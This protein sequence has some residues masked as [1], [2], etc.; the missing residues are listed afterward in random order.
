MGTAWLIFKSLLLLGGL[1]AAVA[2]VLARWWR[3]SD[4]RPKLAVRWGLT[5][6]DLAFIAFVVGPLL[7]S[8]GFTAAFGGVPMAAVAGLILA[9]V[10]T[11]SLTES[12]GRKLVAI[13]DGGDLPPDPKPVYSVAESRR[14]AGRTA[15]ALAELRTQ[16]EQ[17][18][19]DFRLWMMLAEIHADDLHDLETATQAVDQVV[20]QP[21]HAP[22]NVA[23]ALTRLADW[24][25]KYARDPAA[26]REAFERIIQQFPDSEEAHFAHQR[27]AHL[28]TAETLGQ[29]SDRTPL[30]VPHSDE[31]FG[32]RPDFKGLQ[33]PTT[34]PEEEAAR[35]VRQ[36]ERYPHDNQ[37]RE[38]LAQ[39]YVQQ[40]RR[41]DLA[42]EQMEQLIAQPHAPPRQVVHWLNQLA[43]WQL[44]EADNLALARATLERIIARFPDNAVAETA[45]R[46]LATLP[47]EARAN[48]ESQVVQLG[49]YEQ[50]LGLKAKTPPPKGD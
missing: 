46:R 33:L 26:A 14:K 7:K 39:L 11:D 31:H 38:D 6:A 34:P 47:L 29:L 18:P 50:R 30:P 27:L 22:K 17:F 5:L 43:D 23:F 15:E 9:I 16:L 44:R 20:A 19:T 32:L 48:K 2:W 42:T 1:L 37:A 35:L 41:L 12:I 13:Y 3:N 21:G 45:R 40:F 4:D 25:L 8:G 28:A 10:W 49:S 36:L 24:R